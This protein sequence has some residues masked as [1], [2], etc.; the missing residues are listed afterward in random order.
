VF[1]LET[2]TELQRLPA[3]SGMA[4]CGIAWFALYSDNN[5]TFSPLP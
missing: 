3:A 5:S 2:A 1:R 4:D